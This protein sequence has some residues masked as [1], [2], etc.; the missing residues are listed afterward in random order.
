MLIQ[1]LMPKNM[2]NTSRRKDL[3]FSWKNMA[4]NG[5]KTAERQTRMKTSC[6]RRRRR[7]CFSSLVNKL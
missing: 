2:A 4:E 1:A 6:R 3:G 5:G 7:N